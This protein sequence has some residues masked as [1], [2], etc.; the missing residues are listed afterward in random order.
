MDLPDYCAFFL[1]FLHVLSFGSS[2]YT[3]MKVLPCC[4]TTYKNKEWLLSHK[5][6]VRVR[7][8]KTPIHTGW[9]WWPACKSSLRKWKRESLKQADTLGS[10]RFD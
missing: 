5:A 6:E 10:C 3:F 2:T 7:V 8:S 1:A 9:A 4:F